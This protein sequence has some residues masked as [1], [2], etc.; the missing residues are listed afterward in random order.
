[1]SEHVKPAR[2]IVQQLQISEFVSER[3]FQVFEVRNRRRTADQDVAFG[4]S[5]FILCGSPI[6]RLRLRSL[7]PRVSNPDMMNAP[8]VPDEGDSAGETSKSERFL[9]PG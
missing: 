2:E 5:P 9:R 8:R 6:R 1:M 7:F 4:A 3:A